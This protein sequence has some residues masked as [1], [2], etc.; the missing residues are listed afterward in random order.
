MAGISAAHS[1]LLLVLVSRFPAHKQTA[2]F[3]PTQKPT[4]IAMARCI[5][6]D[7]LELRWFQSPMKVRPPA[8]LENR[9]HGSRS[10]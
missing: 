4:V 5:V 7:T 6:M 10:L 1:L 2:I 9:L 8:D 3:H